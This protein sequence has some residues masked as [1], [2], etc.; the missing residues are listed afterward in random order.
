MIQRLGRVSGD[1]EGGHSQ[2]SHAHRN[3]YAKFFDPLHT[4][5]VDQEPGKYSEDKVHRRRPNYGRG[6]LRPSRR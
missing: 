3:A 5:V 4:K 6:Q 2:N 1:G